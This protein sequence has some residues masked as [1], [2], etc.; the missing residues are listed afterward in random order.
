M[1]NMKHV[2]KF[3]LGIV[4]LMMFNMFNYFGMIPKQDW[5]FIALTI[6]TIAFAAAIIVICKKNNITRK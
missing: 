1:N 2:P 4:I 3:A 6:P 5:F